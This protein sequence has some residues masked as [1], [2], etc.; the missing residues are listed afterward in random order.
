MDAQLL[1]VAKHLGEKKVSYWLNSG[2]LLGVVRDGKLLAGDNDIDIGMWWHDREQILQLVDEWKADGYRIVLRKYKGQ[3]CKI[4]AER[5]DD[6]RAKTIDI[7][8]YHK[9]RDFAWCPQHVARLQH[10]SLLY[11]LLRPLHA[12]VSRSLRSLTGRDAK[13]CELICRVYTWWIPARFFE[14]LTVQVVDNIALPVPA[15]AEEYLGYRYGDWRV[16]VRNWDCARDDRAL[17]ASPP[18]HLAR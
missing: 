14:T 11:R 16:P 3:P 10:D 5:A 6:E 4:K 9:W 12:T 13:E 7:D 18:E 8:L 1:E 15:Q 2:T 17:V